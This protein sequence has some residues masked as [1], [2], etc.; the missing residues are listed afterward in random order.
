[1]NIQRI[2]LGWTGLSLLVSSQLFAAGFEKSISWGGQTSGVAGIGS[3]Y[4]QGSQ[5][6]FFNPAGLASDRVGQD[7][8]F[9]ISPTSP[10][11]TGPINNANYVETSQ[12]TI[13]TPFGLIYGNTLTEHLGIGIG[14]FVSGGSK[15]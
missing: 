3:P 13:I 14:A 12:N 7:V 1:M 8:S 5:A 6:L 9:N 15:A 2:L 11:F 10:T 4:I